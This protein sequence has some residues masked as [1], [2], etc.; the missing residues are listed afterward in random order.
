MPR[1]RTRR[2]RPSG[3]IGPP[4]RYALNR[5]APRAGPARWRRYPAVSSNCAPDGPRDLAPQRGGHPR[6]DRQTTLT[7]PDEDDP[8]RFPGS[9]TTSAADPS[10]APRSTPRVPKVPYKALA[11]AADAIATASAPFGGSQLITAGRSWMQA[12]SA[13][14]ART[15]G[16]VRHLR[17]LSTYP[18]GLQGSARC[19]NPH[20]SAQYIFV[21]EHV[22]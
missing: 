4:S 18:R 3:P 20:G 7:E 21:S 15:S 12:T 17:V 16:I 6:N 1:A 13:A 5:S 2:E 11:G 8:T 14:A 10:G 9:Q 19:R 22:P